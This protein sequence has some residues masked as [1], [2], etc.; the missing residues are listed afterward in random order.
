MRTVSQVSSRPVKILLRMDR[1]YFLRKFKFTLL[2]PI[3]TA[4]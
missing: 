4:K 2:M 3:H 1:N